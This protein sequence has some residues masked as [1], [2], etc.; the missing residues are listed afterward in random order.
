MI[1]R[2]ITAVFSLDSSCRVLL[3]LSPLLFYLTNFSPLETGSETEGYEAWLEWVL[4]LVFG[5]KHVI[6]MFFYI[7]FIYLRPMLLPKNS[8]IGDL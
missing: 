3:E 5:A 2:F 1:W 7:F 6:D 8:M 4:C